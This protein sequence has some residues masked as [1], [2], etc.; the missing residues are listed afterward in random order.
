MSK[1]PQH[2]HDAGDTKPPALVPVQEASPE[3][4]PFKPD[5]ELI[6]YI[7]RSQKPGRTKSTRE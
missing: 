7:E 2:P 4:P 5:R 3:A 1:E 6:T